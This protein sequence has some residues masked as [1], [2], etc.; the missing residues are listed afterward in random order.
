MAATSIERKWEGVDRADPA[1]VAG[2]AEEI[3][4]IADRN[5]LQVVLSVGE[6][7]FDRCHS[8]L[9]ERVGPSATIDAVA[10][11]PGITLSRSGLYRA[12]QV[13][14]QYS[15]MPSELRDDLTLS[16]HY[17]LLPLGTDGLEKIPLAREIA[18]TDMPTREIAERV[19]EVLGRPAP[20][21]EKP[22]RKRT[23]AVGAATRLLAPWRDR[24]ANGR[25][26][27]A[28]EAERV[29]REVAELRE[30]LFAMDGWLSAQRV[31]E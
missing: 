12:V 11:E 18:A 8:S 6:L 29:R 17:A 22:T 7:L 20:R 23:P 25:G 5:G 30:L 4:A 3:R 26:P 31:R 14:I 10:K 21:P 27:T 16:Q 28:K 19:R 9:T 15:D 24:I 1:V 13:W 2:L